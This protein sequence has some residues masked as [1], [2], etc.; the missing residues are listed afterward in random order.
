MNEK[1]K[2]NRELVRKLKKFYNYKCQLCS[3]PP[4]IPLI[5]MSNGTDYIEVHHIKG[6]NEIDEG[7]REEVID[8]YKNAITVCCYHHKLLHNYRS[9]I[10]FD[11]KFKMFKSRD[12]RISLPLIINKHI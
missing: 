2:R 11:P 5:P 7:N 6:F 4:E 9:K 3:K 10:V 8:Q 1:Y 12:G